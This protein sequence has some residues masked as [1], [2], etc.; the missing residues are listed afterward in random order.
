MGR[1]LRRTS[2]EVNAS[3]GLFEAEYV[4][5]FGVPFTFLPHEGG[6]GPPPP[7][8]SPKSQIEALSE[9]AHLEISWP[10]VLRVEHVYGP[11]LVL[12]LMRVP[13]LDLFASDSLQLADLAPVVEG[14]PDV[15]RISSIDLEELA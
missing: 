6:D 10:N 9:R 13:P 12:D 1:G 5:I 7:P 3:T 8:P 11:R 14:K 2:Y 15:S 4:N